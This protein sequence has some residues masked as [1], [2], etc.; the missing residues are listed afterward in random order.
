MGRAGKIDSNRAY[1]THQGRIVIK[2]GS[3]VKPS[4]I[5]KSL[6]GGILRSVDIRGDK[7][8]NTCGTGDKLGWIGKVDLR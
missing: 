5:P 6:L 7:L 3:S 2:Q 8:A 4:S 1:A